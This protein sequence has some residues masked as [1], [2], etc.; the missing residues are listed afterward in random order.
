LAARLNLDVHRRD[1]AHPARRTAAMRGAGVDLVLDVGA[2]TGQYV[3]GLRAHGYTGRVESFEAIPVLATELSARA[4]EDGRWRVHG[5]A[6]GVADGTIPFHVSE[7]TVTSSALI[8]SDALLE[9]ISS[10]ST[11]QTI[12]VP[13]H[14]LAGVWADVVGDARSVMLK[15]DVQGFEHAVLDGLADRIDDISLIEVEMGLVGLYEG[16]ASIHDLLPR[17]HDRG[18]TVVSIDSGFVD[19]DSGQVLDIDMLMKREGR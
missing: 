7:D 15:I 5:H 13:C 4:A 11:V 18:F 3:A 1:L 16:G 14:P 2:N 19:R 17:L 6:L 12:D 8:A 9:R 10:A